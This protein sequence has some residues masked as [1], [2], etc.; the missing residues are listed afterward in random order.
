VT[1]E[2]EIVPD[3]DDSEQFL[4][5]NIFDDTIEDTEFNILEQDFE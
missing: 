4:D 1:Y 3:S 5:Q 2:Q